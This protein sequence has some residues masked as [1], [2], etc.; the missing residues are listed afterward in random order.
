MNALVIGAG[1]F[2]QK[3][4]A[5][6]HALDD[7]QV[8]AFCSRTE[9][10][11]RGAAAGLDGSGSV[12]AYTELTRALD[13]ESPDLAVIAVTPNAHGEIEQELTVRGIPFLVEKPI[14][15][16]PQ[17]PAR[18]AAAVAGADL[19]TSVGFHMRYL[20]TAEHLRNALLHENPVLANAWWMGTL[21]PPAWWRHADE[22]GGQL[23]EQTVH[24]ID[25]LRHFLGEVKSVQAVA[26]RQVITSI[27]RDADV[28]DAG[29][30]VLRMES[31]MTATVINSCVA[32]VYLR[33]GVEIVTANRFYRFSPASLTVQRAD[34]TEEFSAAVDPYQLEVEAF[35]EAVRSGDRSAIRSSY[36]DALKTHEVCMAIAQAAGSGRQVE[37]S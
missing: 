27:Y 9:T 29:A 21:P 33:V 7:V 3:H 4:A 26:S 20:D 30:A 24:V 10:S 23:I 11:A 36:A 12:H 22:S 14:G 31:G 8:T 25:L 28:P 15:I 34:A 16:D 17:T 37:L 1:S 18:I 32:P 5:I 35:V 19:V 2:A 13:T 6:L